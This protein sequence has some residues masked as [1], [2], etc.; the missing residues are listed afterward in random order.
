VIVATL[1]EL[2]HSSASRWPD[3]VAVADAAGS[4]ALTYRDLDAIVAELGDELTRH[5]AGQGDSVAIVSD[6]CIEYV[7]ALFAGMG[8]GAS[9]APLNPALTAAEMVST[10]SRLRARA[11]IVPAHLHDDFVATHGAVTSPVWRLALAPGQ[12]QHLRAELVATQH[13]RAGSVR[14]EGLEA[15]PPIA[16]DVAILLLTSGTTAAPKV[17]PLSH[18]NLLASIEGIRSVYRLTPDDATLLVMPLSHG[19]GLVAGLLATLAS[20][21]AAYLPTGG[22]FHASSFWSDMVTAHATWFTAVPTIHQ[23]LLARASSD[24]PKDG[25]PDLRFVRSCSAALA[26]E[27]LQAVEASFSAPVLPAYG[28]TETAHQASSNPLPSDGPDK[29]A[30][31]GVATGVEI[32]VAGPGGVPAASGETGEVWIRGPAVTAGY[33]DNERATA[34]N[35][36]GGWFHT[37]DLGYRDTDGYLFLTGRIKDLINRGGEKISPAA[38]DEVLLSNPDVEDALAFGIP[39][40]KYGEEVAAA[41]V[42]RPGHAMAEEELQRYSRSKLSAVEVPKHIFF[43]ADLPRTAK[44]SGDR[45]RLADQFSK[46]N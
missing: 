39:D 1:S 14:D 17:V 37:G 20:G 6:N 10:L 7:S 43:V 31:V 9:A 25:H 3:R 42:L 11:T 27:V 38:I 30:S 41:V 21:G 26:P 28:M 44:G 16:G 4:R 40:K 34:R 22:R 36:A 45:R 19:H 5:G 33:L 23:I 2:L 35:F 12:H 29:A 46:G 13:G 18:R 8:V 15:H 24:Y 32:Q